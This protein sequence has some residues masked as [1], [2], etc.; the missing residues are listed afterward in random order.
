L[1]NGLNSLD[2]EAALMQELATDDEAHACAARARQQVRRLANQLRSLSTLFQKPQPAA[3]RMPARE[4]FSIWR[5]QQT[6]LSCASE[7]QWVED[8][9]NEEVNVDEMMIATVF[10]ELLSNASAFA[11]GRPL[12]ISARRD[13]N[14]VTFELR[15]PKTNGL[16]PVDWDGAFFTGRR[17]HYGLGLWNVR[18]LV[19]A[20]SGTIT[21]C[22]LEKESVLVTILRL[23]IVS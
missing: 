16:D 8:L 4:L 20:N 19:E 21:R 11:E 2:L 23:P 14:A 5:E 17:G 22:F 7:V 12:T 13:N 9:G 10:R 1:R 15:E 18:R 6:G 3:V